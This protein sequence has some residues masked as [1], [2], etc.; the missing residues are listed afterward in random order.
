MFGAFVLALLFGNRYRKDQIAWADIVD[1]ILALYD[2][3]K[4]GV[5]AVEV[6]GVHTV[7]A[8]KEL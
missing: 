6:L 2:L 3:T 8:D 7:V 4:A 1:Y 5:N